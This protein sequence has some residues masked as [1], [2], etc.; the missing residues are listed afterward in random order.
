MRT[1]EQRFENVNEEQL[2]WADLRESHRVN[3]VLYAE[4]VGLETLVF[5]EKREE[6]LKLCY[7][8]VYGYLPK[9]RIDNYEFKGLHH[10]LGKEFEFV[11]ES[12]DRED[13]ESHWFLANRI[14]AL[15]VSAKRFWRVA[16]EGFVAVGFIRG[17]DVSNLY[18]LVEGVP[19]V[20]NKKEISWSFIEDC[21]LEFEIGDTIDVKVLKAEAPTAENPNGLLE[22][23]AK[24]LLPDPWHKIAHFKEGSSYSG[25]ITKIHSE[26]GVFIELVPGLTVRTN[27]PPN[28]SPDVLQ[29]GKKVSIKVL[30]INHQQKRMKAITIIPNKAISAGRRGRRLV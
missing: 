13:G 29:K 8:G 4:A 19:V 24:A 9:T 27:F 17:M 7:K 10:F 12:I 21:R 16:K 28:A 5:G 1:T 11:V 22:V 26:H 14:V 15:D 30:E 2:A 3:Q 25:T 23:S 20:L 18:L 6:M